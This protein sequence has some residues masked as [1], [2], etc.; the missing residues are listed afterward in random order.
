MNSERGGEKRQH[1]PQIHSGRPTWSPA[2]IDNHPLEMS[3][4]LWETTLIKMQKG[5][6]KLTLAAASFSERVRA[7]INITRL[8]MQIDEAQGAV[9]EEQLAIARKLLELRDVDELPESFEL[10]F[11]S[12][13]VAA[14]LEKIALQEKHL[15]NLL[16]DLENEAGSLK[17][18]AQQPD[19]EKA[20]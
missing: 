3:M 12:D 13:A 16:E 4:N 19:G 11:G 18:A 2:A 7:E 5:Y 17:K 15:D 20:A 9:R 8:R 14:S 1:S 10:F 6:D